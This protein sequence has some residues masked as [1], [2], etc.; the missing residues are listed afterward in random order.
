MQSTW[1]ADVPGGKWWAAKRVKKTSLKLFF[2]LRFLSK[3]KVWGAL[4]RKQPTFVGSVL[5]RMVT[6]L[7]IRQ[8]K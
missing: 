5:K 4:S 3:I 1:L 8:N 7:I 6:V 2:R